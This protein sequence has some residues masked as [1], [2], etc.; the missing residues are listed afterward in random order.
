MKQEKMSIV[1]SGVQFQPHI[2]D[3]MITSYKSIDRVSVL[4]SLEVNKS[5]GGHTEKSGSKTERINSR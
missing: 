3:A 5:P 2:D 4:F 1:C